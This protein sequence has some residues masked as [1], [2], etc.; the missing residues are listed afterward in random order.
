M[1]WW[2]RE[3][4]EEVDPGLVDRL[5][6]IYRNEWVIIDFIGA[7]LEPP[8]LEPPDEEAAAAPPDCTAGA[9]PVVPPVAPRI[10]P[11]VVPPPNRRIDRNARQNDLFGPDE[12]SPSRGRNVPMTRTKRPHDADETSPKALLKAPEESPHAPRAAPPRA[13]IEIATNPDR[14]ELDIAVEWE[15]RLGLTLRPREPRQEDKD[16]QEIRDL[17]REVLVGRFGD[18]GFILEDLSR[19]IHEIRAM[20]ESVRAPLGLLISRKF[21]PLRAQARAREQLASLKRKGATDMDIIVTT[22]KAQ[23]PRPR[24]PRRPSMHGGTTT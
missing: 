11:P 2:L 10:T 17:I 12:T 8:P 23:N 19:T 21:Q 24:W 5:L 7:A 15:E 14:N 6:G 1:D 9:P 16:L 18:P 22:P 3:H 4:A 13:S 20:G